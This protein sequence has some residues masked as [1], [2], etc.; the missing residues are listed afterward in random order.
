M[1]RVGWSEGWANESLARD[2]IVVITQE[3]I[4]HTTGEVVIDDDSCSL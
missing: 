3:V 2:Y 4:E 1:D